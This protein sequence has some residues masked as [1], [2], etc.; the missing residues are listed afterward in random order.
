MQKRIFSDMWTGKNI[1]GAV[2]KAVKM[3]VYTSFG[4]IINKMKG[5]SNTDMSW[6]SNIKAYK[7]NKVSKKK[8]K[9]EKKQ[10]NV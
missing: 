6:E 2:E 10:S 7:Q 9:R 4:E 5:L 1:N 3:P 8:V